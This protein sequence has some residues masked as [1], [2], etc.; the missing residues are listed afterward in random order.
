MIFR[1]LVAACAFTFAGSTFAQVISSDFESG[2]DGWK[3]R[4]Y[5]TGGSQTTPA[6]DGHAINTG[7]T[8]DLVAFSAPGPKY[9]GDKAMYFG[10]TVQFD[11]YDQ[12]VSSNTAV[13]YTLAIGTG[14][15][16][17]PGATVLHW[18]GGQ[19]STIDFVHFTATLSP[20]DS[21]WRIGGG[22]TGG[23]LPPTVEQFKAVLGDI[24][25]ILVNA[26]WH[27][28]DLDF[29]RLDN[30]TITPVPEVGTATLLG[31]GLLLLAARRIV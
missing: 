31:V 18:Y 27:D 28:G 15:S 21:R 2:P 22:P 16:S 8:A 3:T 12:Y 6:Y 5:F 11:L 26:D 14:A 13:T 7:D 20:S 19:P 4:D 17:V 24:R 1:S 29:A 23:G 30:F 10:G 9:T 25:F